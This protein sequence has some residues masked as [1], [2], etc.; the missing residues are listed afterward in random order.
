MA[1]P[2][3]TAPAAFGFDGKQAVAR[4]SPWAGAIQLFED[5]AETI[6]LDITGVLDFIMVIEWSGTAGSSEYTT[7]NGM[8]IIDPAL[9]QL[10]W[11]IEDLTVE[12]ERGKYTMW[13][14]FNGSSGEVIV[15]IL[16][17]PLNL[18]TELQYPTGFA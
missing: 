18:L 17:G 3:I 4:H 14:K 2:G 9:G 16:E 6:P 13:L 11:L 15:P 12:A 7:L 1:T 10:A 5:K 8:Q